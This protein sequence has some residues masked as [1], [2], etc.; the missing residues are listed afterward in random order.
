MGRKEHSGRTDQRKAALKRKAD[1]HKLLDKDERE[2][3]RGAMYLGGYAI[4]CKLKSIAMEVYGC[5]TFD[6]LADEW[7]VSEDVVYS[8]GLEALATRLPLYN[9]MKKDSKTWRD[10]AGLVNRWRPSWRYD[11]KD[12]SVDAAE[13][14]LDA[15]DRVYKWLESNKC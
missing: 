10:F 13:T 9:R 6:Q 12:W 3:A 1:A 14:F 2:H 8:H 11:P 4:E 5:W 15:V 7:Q